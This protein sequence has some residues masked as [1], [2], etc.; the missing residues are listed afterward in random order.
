LLQRVFGAVFLEGLLSLGRG[1]EINEGGAEFIIE[2]S[3]L[4]I[5]DRR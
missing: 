2:G 1:G 5:V 4:Q 3:L